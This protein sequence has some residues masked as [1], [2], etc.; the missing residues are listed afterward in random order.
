MFGD[1]GVVDEDV[2]GECPRER[3][4]GEVFFGEGE[5][6]FDGGDGVF[7]VG[8]DAE[9][10]DGVFFGEG[11]AELIGAGGGGCGGVVEDERA[12][13]RG[14]VFR[15]GGADACRC[16]SSLLLYFLDWWCCPTP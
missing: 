9:A 5:D 1:A 2:D 10:A 14:E 13:F 15:D 12:A 11:F 3:V 16:Q 8:L 6:L 7:E 4:F